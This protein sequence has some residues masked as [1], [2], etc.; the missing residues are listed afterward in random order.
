MLDG[1]TED[2]VQKFYTILNDV[3]DENVS[4]SPECASSQPIWYTS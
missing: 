3:I 4:D 2:C 1:Y